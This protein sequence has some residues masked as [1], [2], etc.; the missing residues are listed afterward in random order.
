MDEIEDWLVARIATAVNRSPAEISVDEHLTTFGLSSLAALSIA[1]D[2]EDW[3][4]R[5]L[6]PTVVWDYPTIA[7]LSAHL[8]SQSIEPDSAR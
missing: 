6:E 5:K 1:G 8:A 4:G 2:L 3:L 7:R